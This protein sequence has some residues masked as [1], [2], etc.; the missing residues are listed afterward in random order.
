MTTRDYPRIV[1]PPPGPKARAIVARDENWTSTCYIKEY[2][3]VVARGQGVMIEDVDGNRF[4]DFMAGIAVSSTGYGHPKVVAAVKD[5]ADRFLHICGS[6]FYY[7]GMAQLCERL[8]LLAPG[9]SKK[10]VF[11]TNSGTEAVEGAIKL[12][13][14]AT[15]RTAIIAFRGAFHGRTTGAVTLTSS[16][17]RQH[18]G[19]G[20]L[21]P[22]VHH[23][24]FAY[25]YRCQFCASEPA[26]NR[27]CLDVIEQELFTRQLDPQDVAAIFVEPVQGEGG[28]IVPPPGYLRGLR[29]M[30]DRY[31]ILLVADE[32]QCGVGRT[33]KMFACE[34]EGVE[35]DILLT[36][37]GLGSGMPI[38]AIV[39]KD[40]VTTWK[41]GSHGSTFGGNPVCCAAA[42]A[43]LD[44]V[45]GGLMAN[46]VR[47]G[48]RLISAA[49]RL[50]DKHPCIG[51]VR[52][53]GLMVGVEF[54]KDRTT[55]EPAG[56]LVHELVQRAFQQG[57]LLLGAGKSTLR[58]APP[59]IISERD[60][61]TAVGMI[62]DILSHLA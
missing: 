51:D 15:R 13:R 12:A 18:A 25:R 17:A 59:L 26:C 21:L 35:P 53:Q 54:V 55:R 49:R 22:D 41:T 1:V 24:P 43:T 32:V 60:V 8:A 52:G 58:L 39:A 62:D 40:S 2:P 45:E 37:K 30:C 23:V 57:L 34:H 28:Y 38:G 5:A 36:A 56:D 29:E 3:L 11:L 47:M 9:P 48:D 10:R 61:D 6:D 44:V 46:A 7:E 4:L 14:Y 42:L 16:K 19:F 33:G 31:G 50:M 20:P 27:G